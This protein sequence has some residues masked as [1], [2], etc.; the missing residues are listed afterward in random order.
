MKLEDIQKSISQMET[1]ELLELVAE[2]RKKRATNKN[3]KQDV[4]A[5]PKG[6]TAAQKLKGILGSLSPE[7]QAA[8]MAELEGA[9]E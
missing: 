6:T 9:S 5:S 4:P 8:L 7:E 1:N 2:I 3:I